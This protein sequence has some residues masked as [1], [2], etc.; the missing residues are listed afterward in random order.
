MGNTSA[1]GLITDT[2]AP[3]Q[4]RLFIVGR[5]HNAIRGVSLIQIILSHSWP[6]I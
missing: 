5:D 4:A 3:C 2:A 1:P 6:W